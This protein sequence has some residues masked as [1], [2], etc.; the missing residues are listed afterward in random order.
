MGV[1][2]KGP[3]MY[4]QVRTEDDVSDCATCPESVLRQRANGIER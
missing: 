2:R 4:D 3:A 1:E